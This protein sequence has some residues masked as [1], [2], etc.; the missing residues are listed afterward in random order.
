MQETPEER[1]KG[2]VIHVIGE[3]LLWVFVGVLCLA[4]RISIN[5]SITMGFCAAVLL[6][7]F[8]RR[9]L[10]ADIDALDDP[11]DNPRA[12]RLIN[13]SRERAHR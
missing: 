2:A 6:V 13:S 8:I 9:Y 1:A 7:V 5:L 10:Q 12:N 11:N 4:S 3:T